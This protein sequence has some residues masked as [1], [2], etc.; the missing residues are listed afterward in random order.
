MKRF[1]ENLINKY[2]YFGGGPSKGFATHRNVSKLTFFGKI[3][4]AKSVGFRFYS[5]I[6]RSESR[7]RSRYLEITSI[8]LIFSLTYSSKAE[9]LF[10]LARG[11]NRLTSATLQIRGVSKVATATQGNLPWKIA[12]KLCTSVGTR[13]GVQ[14]RDF[15]ACFGY[16]TKWHRNYLRDI[17]RSLWV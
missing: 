7:I 6:W 3:G 5:G 4:H 17:L 2:I 10:W 16:L 9:L 12:M 11:L 13:L 1:P 15:S 8:S 14:V